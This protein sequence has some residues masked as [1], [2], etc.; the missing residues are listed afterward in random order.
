MIFSN[1]S[2]IIRQPEKQW[3]VFLKQTYQTDSILN[4]LNA[5]HKIPYWSAYNFSTVVPKH[6]DVLLFSL[7]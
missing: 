7:C 6:D 5:M 4:N 2:S 3:A 1:F